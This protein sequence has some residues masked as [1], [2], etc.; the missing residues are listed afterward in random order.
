VRWGSVQGGRDVGIHLITISIRGR[1]PSTGVGM[2]LNWRSE[3]S[4]GGNEERRHEGRERLWG[5]EWR[6]GEKS[7]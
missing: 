6:R 5:R 1:A 7:T 2:C 4:G 3:T